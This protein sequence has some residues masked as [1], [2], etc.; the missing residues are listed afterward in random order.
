MISILV[1]VYNEEES[2]PHFYIELVK[3]LNKFEEG[4]EVLFVDDGSTDRSLEILKDFANNDTTVR[5]FSLRKNEGKA[6]ALTVGF[7]KSRGDYIITLDAD[8]QD[9][10][11]EIEK[12]V[13]KMQEGFDLVSGWRQNRK[14]SQKLIIASKVFNYLASVF[15]GLNLH[16]YNCGLKIYKK[17]VAKSLNLYGGLHR[18]I[19]LIAYQ[20]G[21]SVTE[22]PI[23]HDVRRFG[24]AKYGISKLWK[25]IPDIFT[26][27]FLA[28]YKTKPLHFFGTAGGIMFVIGFVIFSY[29]SLIWLSGESIGT[30]PLLLL[31]VLLMIAGLQVLFTGFIAEL[32]ISISSK[33]EIH[34]P[35]KFTTDKKE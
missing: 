23:E 6:E 7:Q 3:E 17:E 35:L 34:F 15:W 2:L 20:Q 14:H 8:L 31:S 22:V 29:L 33:N 16:D 25:D 13:K 21:F 19:P 1:P 5:V 18:F 27:L 9:K 11:S 4:Y 24:K 30:R 12:L 26:M 32:I 28:K 10:P